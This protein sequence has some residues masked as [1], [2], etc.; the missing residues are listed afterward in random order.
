MAVAV[1]TQQ[2][3]FESGHSGKDV[4]SDLHVAFTPQN[5]GG[6]RIE[7]RSRVVTYY[8]DSIRAQAEQVLRKLGVEHCHLSIADEGALP[9]VISA[10]IE[11]AVKKSGLAKSARVLPE[12]S[13]LP[14]ALARD[15]LRRS[16]LYLPGAEP[17]YFVNAGL[18]QPDAIILDLEDSVH[19]SDTEK[20]RLLTAICGH[21]HEAASS[22]R[23]ISLKS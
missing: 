6:L 8:G 5:A 3:T 23:K 18:H 2:E 22:E 1:T 7:L 11:A 17:K 4:R 16:R 14:P 9:F 10:R 12:Q 15:R 20:R 21:W 13:P 19:T